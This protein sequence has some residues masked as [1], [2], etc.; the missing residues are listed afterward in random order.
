[1][2][3]PLHLHMIKETINIVWFKRDLRIRDHAPLAKAIE[4]G[5]PVLLCTFLEPSEKRTKHW[6]PRHWDFRLEAIGELQEQL[7]SKRTLYLFNE[8]V[9]PVFCLLRATFDIQHIFSHQETGDKRSFDRD[10][11]V[12]QFCQTHRITWDESVQDGIIRGRK[13]R[14]GWQ[15]QWDA[16][17]Q[18]PMIHPDIE[19]LKTVHVKENE[20]MIEV[21]RPSFESAFQP[22]GPVKAMRYLNGFLRKRGNNYHRLLSK[23][24]ESRWSCSRLSP[25]LAVGSIGVREIYQRSLARAQTDLSWKKAMETFHSRLWWRSHYTQKL[26]AEWQ[27]EFQPINHGFEGFERPDNSEKLEILRT[28]QTG[29]PLVDACMRCLEQTGWLNFRMRAMLATFGTFAWWQSREAISVILGRTFL[30]YD[31]GIHFAQM[32]MQSGLSGYH[33]LRIFNPSIQAEQHDP[34]GDFIRKYV[35]ELGG[36]PAPQI[37]RP[38]TMTPMEQSFFGCQLGRDYP[39]PIIDYDEALRKNRDAYW[40]YRQSPAVV[41]YLPTL[42]ER[43]CLPSDVATYQQ[44]ASVNNEGRI[45]SCD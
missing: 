41:N 39:V 28:G 2:D 7:G 10:R 31:P 4:A 12:K 29:F 11:V 36:V 13:H 24:E 20:S 32:Q 30:D 5:L 14:V 33:P 34:Q 27:I 23:P 16:F 22:G 17:V 38:W 26:E 9:I 1:M 44:Q 3:K 37:F 45:S 21:Q 35:P 19:R 25:Y 6:S 40:A 8:E 15:E 43:H 42:W 18:A